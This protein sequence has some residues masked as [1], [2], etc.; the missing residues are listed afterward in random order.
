MANPPRGLNSKQTDVAIKWMSRA[1]TWVI[2]KTNGKFG[3]KFLRGAPVGI[4]TAIGRKT[5][6]PRESP[7]LYLR[8][9]RRVILVASSGGRANNPMWYL[10]P[11]RPTRRSPFRSRTRCST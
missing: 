6:E 8:E 11:S 9:G 10:N 1:Q 5:G 2:K 3:D 7:L 4:L